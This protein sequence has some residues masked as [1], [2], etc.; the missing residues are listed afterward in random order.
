MSG[1]QE[2]SGAL[3]AFAQEME[4]EI[5]GLKNENP[6]AES[7][8]EVPK[9]DEISSSLAA[10][11]LDQEEYKPYEQDERPWYQ[12]NDEQYQEKKEEDD[13]DGEEEEGEEEEDD[14]ED[15]S[16]DGEEDEYE[17]G[18]EEDEE[19]ES[20]VFDLEGTIEEIKGMSMPK[21]RKQLTI[22]KANLAQKEV[23][24]NTLKKQ[25][26]ESEEK[27]QN[28]EK[29]SKDSEVA[30]PKADINDYEPWKE[31]LTTYHSTI[32]DA[33]SKMRPSKASILT[34]KNV[35]ALRTNWLSIRE[36]DGTDYDEAKQR[37]DERIDEQFGDD[38]RKVHNLIDDL[39]GLS[40]K[41]QRVTDEFHKNNDE[42]SMKIASENYDKSYSDA[43][44][45]ASR[46]YEDKSSETE[47]TLRNFVR[48]VVETGDKEDSIKVKRLIKEDAINIAKTLN[49]NGPFDPSDKKW[50]GMDKEQAF[51]SWLTE[52]KKFEQ[53]RKELVPGLLAEALMSR[54]FHPQLLQKGSNQKTKKKTPKPSARKTSKKRA[55]KRNADSSERDFERSMNA[56]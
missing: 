21:I 28:A 14:Y 30:V 27:I 16:E 26:E 51:E 36:L 20:P 46:I 4:N 39:A 56:W 2:Q 22:Q 9:K 12:Q 49:G 13:S 54:R 55:K 33:K 32:D 17:D 15:S 29:S 44:D 8:D 19:E 35:E 10:G 53:I 25:V 47:M 1:E 31:I 11:P 52:K 34:D 37:F 23:E 48:N 18:D 24:I 40:S 5:S 42:I 38:S 7:I 41:A 50:E 6:K 43:I 45:I 3:E